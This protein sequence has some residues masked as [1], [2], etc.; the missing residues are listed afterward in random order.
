[1]RKEIKAHIEAKAADMRNRCEEEISRMTEDAEQVSIRTD[2]MES[3]IQLHN[4]YTS[5]IEAG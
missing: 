1:M 2:M 3:A 5:Y 4:M